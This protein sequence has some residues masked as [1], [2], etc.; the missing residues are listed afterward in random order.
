MNLSNLILAVNLWLKPVVFVL[1]GLLM[2]E[3]GDRLPPFMKAALNVPIDVVVVVLFAMALYWCF[4]AVWKLWQAHEG[5]GEL[6]HRCGAP[7][8][9]ISP[10]RYSPHYRCL[11]C[12]ANRKADS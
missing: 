8:R 5:L 11:A 1:A 7:T 3:A 6:C 12:G 4:W 10:G 2:G 9:L